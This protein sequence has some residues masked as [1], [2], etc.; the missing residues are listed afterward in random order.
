M[1]TTSAKGNGELPAI[2]FGPV[3]SRRLGRSLGINNVPPKTCSYACVYC[4]LGRTTRMQTDRVAT[5]SPET[6]YEEVGR[7]VAVAA[8]AEEAIDYLTFVSDGE[9]T[10]DLQLGASIDRLRSTGVPIAVI[11][12]ASLLW[13]EDVRRDLSHADWVSVKVDAADEA[14]WRRIDRPHKELRFERIRDGLFAFA[15]QYR[16]RLVTETMLVGGVNDDKTRID[17]IAALV[18]RLKPAIAYVAAPIR[19]PAER[20]AGIPAM[21]RVVA[22]HEALAARVDSVELLTGY[23][24][25]AFAATGSAEENLLEITAV[26][27]MREDAVG[28][29][30]ARTG[31]GEEVLERLV[32]AGR[33]V[34]LDHGGHVYYVRDFAGR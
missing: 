30:L 29:L 22:A 24:G 33:L 32:G 9:P 15:E 11:T 19:P 7:R 8:R 17:G 20:W 3:P 12:N 18:G 21:D 1:N 6:I 28:E 23:E 2:V 4:Q 31:E 5:Y 13:R 14:T 34:R 16:G 26:H 25:N 27:P 10:L